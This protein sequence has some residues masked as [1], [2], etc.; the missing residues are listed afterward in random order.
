MCAWAGE[1]G[2]LYSRLSQASFYF[3]NVTFLHNSKNQAT[4]DSDLFIRLLSVILVNNAKGKV[5][6]SD[7]Q[8]AVWYPYGYAYYRASKQVATNCEPPFAA[9]E[10]LGGQAFVDH[11]IEWYGV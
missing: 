5:N 8:T 1:G 7:S 4:W 2:V 3:R 6:S 11:D 10:A 9:A